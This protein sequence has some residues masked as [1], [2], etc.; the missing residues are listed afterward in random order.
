MAGS[1]L[2]TILFGLGGGIPLFTLAWI[3][4]RLV[5]SMGWAGMIKITSRSA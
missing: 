5:Q 1:I 4:N 3:G 2:F